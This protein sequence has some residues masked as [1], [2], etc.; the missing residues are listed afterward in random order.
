[1]PAALNGRWNWND[2]VETINETLDAAKARAVEP[3]QVDASPYAQ[4][5]PA[6]LMAVTLYQIQIATN[7]ALNNHIYE[8]IRS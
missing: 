2:L 4:F 8:M 1:V 5:L 7:L 3:A 6:T